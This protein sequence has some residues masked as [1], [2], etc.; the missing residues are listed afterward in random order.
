MAIFYVVFVGLSA[1]SSSSG[2]RNN[3]GIY[4]TLTVFM[5]ALSVIGF[6]VTLARAPRSLA[7]RDDQLVV[8][9]RLGKLRRFHR[10]GLRASVLF[11]YPRSFLA[12]DPTELVTITDETGRRHHYLVGQGTLTDVGPPA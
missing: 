3:P 12:A 4:G 1:T 10:D 5:L 11:R 7:W 2:V 6:L 8:R 9:E